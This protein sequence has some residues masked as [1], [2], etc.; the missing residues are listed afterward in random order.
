[1]MLWTSAY[2]DSDL[3]ESGKSDAMEA[4]IR[5]LDARAGQSNKLYNV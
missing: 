1:M 2:E 4:L 5:V 3:G